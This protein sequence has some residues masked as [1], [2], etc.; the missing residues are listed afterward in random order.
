[1]TDAEKLLAIKSNPIL[2]METFVRVPNKQGIVVPFKLTPQQ[3]YLMRHKQKYNITL[4]SRQLGISTV[5]MAYSLYI[6]LNKANATC[7][8]MSFS[9]K[10]V[11]EIFS[12]LRAIYDYLPDYV[13]LEETANNRTELSFVNNSKIIVATCG[14]KDN[15]RGST[16]AFC[17]LSEVG[18]MNE[19][20][21]TQLI[22][23]EQA[24][25]PGGCM[26]LESTAK[27]L[28]KFHELWQGSVS[29]ENNY[30]PFFFAW[31]KDKKMFVDEYKEFS[32]VWK[33]RNGKYLTEDELDETEQWLFS[34]GTTLQ[35]LMWR[36]VKIKNIGED[37]FCQE[38]P[39]TPEEAFLNSDGANIFD[40]KCIYER[41]I[42]LDKH[43]PVLK[44][45]KD[46][47]LKIKQYKQYLKIWKY[48]KA[49][50]KYYF[51]VDTAEGLGGSHDYSVIEAYDIDGF[52]CAEFRSN[53]VKPYLFAEVLNELAL[54]YN[55]ALLCIERA[56]AGMTVI[57]K[58]RNTYKYYNMMKYKSFDAKGKK[59]SKWG[60][61]TSQISKPK[62]INNFVEMF[63]T[64][65]MCINSKDL[66]NEMK[67]FQSIDGRM[68]AVSG[69]DDTVMATALAIVAMLQKYHYRF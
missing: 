4:K 60:W 25:V 64:G 19:N 1:M 55:K 54:Y 53:K 22:A 23:I 46:L 17:H 69:H 5:S 15:A 21:E 50:E 45:P 59:T 26:I 9:M 3:K 31:Y 18:L 44:I 35:M 32:E 48:P 20:L 39:A 12:K 51:G 41:I 2:W 63:E 24:L 47:P 6:T 27:G 28:N 37:A 38:F 36:R 33:A 65:Q 61:E 10:S 11:S 43:F 68:C 14:S 7:L 30:Y 16:L 8:L 66:L 67:L 57:E 29:E 52:Q 34:Q 56:S 40:V 49:G 62:M 42:N 13:K 58:M